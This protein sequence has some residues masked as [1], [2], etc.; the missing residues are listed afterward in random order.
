MSYTRNPPIEGLV[1]FPLPPKV[2][3]R[4]SAASATAPSSASASIYARRIN[5]LIPLSSLDPAFLTRDRKKIV[6]AVAVEPTK[7]YECEASGDLWRLLTYDLQDK[8]KDPSFVIY[9]LSE[10]L[11]VKWLGDFNATVV[12]DTPIR[13]NIRSAIERAALQCSSDGSCILWM[14]CNRMV[15]ESS[16]IS[17]MM[18]ADGWEQAL[19]GEDLKT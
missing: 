13:A 17:V 1:E 16:G 19:T 10:R 4:Q 6:V 7:G 12:V 2:S 11:N 18:P 5:R 8:L 14:A 3:S 15:Q 9:I